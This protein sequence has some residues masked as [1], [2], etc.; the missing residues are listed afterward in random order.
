MRTS[1]P[2]QWALAIAVAI[3]FAGAPCSPRA[4]DQ[5]ALGT[6][7]DHLTLVLP[8]PQP[9]WVYILEPAFPN[10]IVSKVWILD[11]DTLEFKGML[12]AGA[13][14][15]FV[16]QPDKSELYVGETFWSRGS[17]GDRTDVV[18]IYDTK[19]LEPTTEVK[20][21]A[22]RFLVVPKKPNLTLT[23]DGRYLLSV[24]MD[25]SVS[26]SVVDTKARKYLGEIPAGGCNLTY[27]TGPASFAMLCADGSFTNT[28]FDETGKATTENGRPFFDSENDPV[29]EHAAQHRASGQAFFISYKGVVYPTKLD[30]MPKVG[31]SWQLQEPG[32]E[33]WRP[34][35]WQLAAFHAATNRLFVLMHQGGPW[36]HKQAGEEIWVFDATTHKRVQRVPLALHSTSI[37]VSQDDQ[38]LLYALTET[39]ALQ[40]F[41]ATSYAAKATKTGIGISPCCLYTPGE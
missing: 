35:G 31:E 32:D 4:Q 39:A 3:G 21:P 23:S 11:A 10:L 5:P 19:T 7:E 37:S 28:T 20:L 27:P 1:R 29:F 26:V 14:A 15:T 8:E 18:T 9:H 13:L 41:D 6:Q 38:P 24:N 25:P 33:G 16:M 17:R 30:G 34:G 40:V 22:G 2:W 36:T 12:S